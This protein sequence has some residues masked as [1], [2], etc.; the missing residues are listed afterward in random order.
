MNVYAS[1]LKF[2]DLSDESVAKV[3]FNYFLRQYT[4]AVSS[5][6]QAR[7]TLSAMEAA[8]H[9]YGREVGRDH[10]LGVGSWVRYPYT[11]S[12]IEN[13]KKEIETTQTSQ[14]EGERI[15]KFLRDRLLEKFS[16]AE[17]NPCISD[18]TNIQQ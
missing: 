5:A 6:T 9:A 15:I 4:D 14:K 17:K 2:S 7:A 13:Q 12:Q 11:D 8:N 16:L 10:S 1:I 3:I 18:K